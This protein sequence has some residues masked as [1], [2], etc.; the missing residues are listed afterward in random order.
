[1][2]SPLWPASLLA[3]C[4][5]C[6]GPGAP[7][8]AGATP[9]T[10]PAVE[11]RSLG[12][13]V[14]AQAPAGGSPRPLTIADLD[15]WQ[16]IESGTLSHR[17]RW[18]AY[19]L[20]PADRTDGAALF[21]STD[22]ARRFEVPRGAAPRVTADERF[23]VARV[24]PPTEA[25]RAARRAGKKD[26]DLP[27]PGML[28]VDLQRGTSTFVRDVR[29]F[30]VPEVGGSALAYLLERTAP[31]AAERE[32]RPQ[33]QRSV[34]PE[35][36]ERAI[37]GEKPP[38]HV[39]DHEDGTTLVVLDLDTGRERRF[40]H[41]TDFRFTRDGAWL[42]FVTATKSEGGDGVWVLATRGDAEPRPV[43]EGEG[44]YQS[45]TTDD[46][47]TW[48]AFLTDRGEF[49]GKAPAFEVHV[50][51]LAGGAG[52]TVI[53][54]DHAGL[55]RGWA[56]SP[57]RAPWFSRSG[58][59][60]YF[61]TAPVAEPTPE[62]ELEELRVD[63]D[64]WSHTDVDLQSEQLVERQRERERSFLAVAHLGGGGASVTASVVQ[65]GGPDLHEV[66]VPG[67]GDGDV[68]L[69]LHDVPYREERQWD[70]QARTDVFAL[71]VHTGARW[72]I[73]TA[74][75]A[76]PAAS[77]SGRWLHW[78][79]LDRQ[80]WFVCDVVAA[81]AG[82]AA[83]RALRTASVAPFAD[84]ENDRPERR[85]AY[86]AGGWLADDSRLLLHSEFDVWAFD[87]TGASPPVSPTRALGAARQ[88]RFRVLD[89]DPREPGLGAV[90]PLVLTSF[91]ETTKASGF[92]T[93]DPSARGAPV[94]R[95]R[96]DAR[97][98]ALTRA[99]AAEVVS[100]T[101]E[102]YRSFPDVWC[103]DASFAS[104]RRVTEANP[105][106]LEFR[107]GRAQPYA[108]RD[109]TGGAREGILCVPDDFD[110]TRR[111]PTLVYFY[112][113][114]ADDLHEH[115][116]PIPHRSMVRFPFYTSRGYVVF[117]PDI[118]Y[119][120]GEPGRS[121]EDCVL[122]GIDSLIAAGIADPDRIGVQGH[123]W[124]G[125]QIAHLVTRTARFRCAVSGAPVA[126]MTS[127]YGGLRYA[128]GI[129]RQWQYER[130]QSR[131]GATLWDARERY[132]ENS[133]VFFL[134]KVVTPLLILHNDKDGAVPW[135]QGL[136]LFLALR[137]LGRA[138]W[139]LNYN[140]ED[141]GLARYAHRRDYAQRMAQFFDHFLMDAPAPRWMT[142]GIPAVAKGRDLALDTPT[143]A[144]EE[145]Q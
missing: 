32:H 26:N 55:P 86:G 138:A 66:E 15:R 131:I 114:S 8:L 106:A 58:S 115:W 22:R 100:F 125:Y 46:G 120:T 41:V 6:R 16:T 123:S 14:E 25:L 45:L 103:A 145:P 116:D 132:I 51:R 98:G 84:E 56:P 49:R 77:P 119:R 89:L 33:G 137:R 60:L 97:F 21:V 42:A 3:A 53:G 30:E 67:L 140:G 5:G 133:P 31:D 63:L 72:P 94:E 70:R 112:E 135:T 127:A 57:H 59:R 12:P 9:E 28:V 95:I 68:A 27:K 91:E 129:S 73:A 43:A 29:R 47:G 23:G 2:R 134:D 102:D 85:S 11:V 20:R 37:P 93:A 136:E 124:G 108:W 38:A 111:Y 143:R 71:D 110:P 69:G 18:F 50:T 142:T 78:W 76:R 35:A 128:T 82:A 141:H 64:L 83:T 62:E 96:G 19:E 7:E 126:N 105:R 107:W 39:R 74:L 52:A 13:L 90:A 75:R 113:K 88:T 40:A 65:L 121:A 118:V 80:D 34:A 99:Q 122:S 24:T 44:R 87:P 4:V 61:G 104:P 92:W 17:G 48:L 117:V 144:T 139:L 54:R 1:M 109:S 101:R 10:S 36:P 79:D 130:S 81:R